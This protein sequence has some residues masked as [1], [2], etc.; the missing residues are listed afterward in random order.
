MD[1]RRMLTYID[2]SP[3]PFHACA[4]AA[5]RLEAAGFTALAEVDAWPAAPG[6]HFVQRGGSLVAWQ[7]DGG[8]HRPPPGSG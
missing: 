4:E 6:R 2:A 8:A 7:T 5:A 3:S 1:A